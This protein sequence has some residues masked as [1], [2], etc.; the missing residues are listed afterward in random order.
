[1]ADMRTSADTGAPVPS[2]TVV[3]LGRLKGL[4]DGVVAI[5]LTLLVLGIR[6]PSG[7]SRG[8]LPATV[9]ALAPQIGVYLIAFV[10]IG[11]AWASHQRMLGQLSRG[12]GLLVWFT[13]LFLLPVTLVPAAAALLGDHPDA[14]FAVAI[15]AADVIAIQLASAWLWR[16]ASRHDLV[17]PSLD[18]RV[19]TAIGRRL[20]FSAGVFLVSIPLAYVS[21][22]IAYLLW[23]LAFA[24]IFSTDWV[25]WRYALRTTT[26][27]ISSDGVKRARIRVRHAGGMLHIRAIKPG[28]A[29]VE[30]TFGGGLRKAMSVTDGVAVVDLSIPQQSGL[31]NPR[32]PWAWG[33]SAFPDWDVSF[34]SDVPLEL[35][36]DNF[37]GLAFLELEGLRLTELTV[38]GTGSTTEV[39]MPSHAGQTATRIEVRAGSVDVRIPD[40]V[41]AAIRPS[42]RSAEVMLD[43]DRFPPVIGGKGWRSANYDDAPN[44]LDIEVKLWASLVTIA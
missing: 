13:L 19:V 12:D 26:D 33:I 18:P 4:S 1:M 20:I 23:I 27:A 31:L 35:T 37:G 8:D 14:A 21:P 32:F 40:G 17:H 30:G 16:H 5:A 34:S 11:G 39:G 7:V 15:F 41:A 6:V 22:W 10:V 24:L 36:I 38:H 3:E 2:E 25:S 42:L 28:D 43:P 44:R 29:L 9:V